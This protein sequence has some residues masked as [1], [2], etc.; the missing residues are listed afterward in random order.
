MRAM[1]S[2]GLP[3]PR[4]Y[5]SAATIWLAMAMS[6]LDASIANVALPTLARELG[7]TAAASVWLQAS[8]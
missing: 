6:V 1:E 3:V 7:S 5:W 2:D 4:R 8:A